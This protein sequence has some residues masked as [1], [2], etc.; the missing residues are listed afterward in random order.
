MGVQARV[1]RDLLTLILLP[2]INAQDY[3]FNF[4]YIY[5]LSYYKFVFV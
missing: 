5:I 3:M 4:I 2:N 1:R